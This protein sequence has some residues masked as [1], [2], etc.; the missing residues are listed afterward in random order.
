MKLSQAFKSALDERA[1]PYMRLLC[2]FG[3]RVPEGINQKSED[4]LDK[5]HGL[6]FVTA[7]F[8]LGGTCF[9]LKLS[10]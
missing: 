10:A 2:L 4:K 9:Y 3:F 5:K 7:S 1:R 8:I 6:R